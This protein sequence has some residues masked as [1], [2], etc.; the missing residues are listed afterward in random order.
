MKTLDIIKIS[1]K[2]LFRSKL[3][4]FLTVAAVFIGALTL[5]LTNG[6]GSGIKAYV[7]EQIGNVGAK[8]TLVVQM[9]QELNPTSNE[10]KKYNPNRKTGGSFNLALLGKNDIEKIKGTAGVVEVTPQYTIRLE[11]VTTGGDKYESSATQYIEGLTLAMSAGDTVQANSTDT[12]TIPDKYV[13]PLGFSSDQDAIGKALTIAFKDVSGKIV[14]RKIII[15]GVQKQSLLGSSGVNISSALAKE[16]NL[17]QTTGVSGLV[18]SYQNVIAKYDPSFSAKQISDLKERLSQVGYSSQTVEEQLGT[19]STIINTILIVL[20]VF[21]A[22]TLLAATFG[23]VNTLLMSVNER[24]SEIGLMKALGAKR[25]TVFSI[26]ALEAASIGFWGAL[27]GV[28]V[29]MGVGSIVSNIATQ[30]FLQNFVGFQ[31]VAF[32]LLPSLAVLIGIIALA[33]LAGAL[34]SLKASKLDPIKALRY[35]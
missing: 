29:S 8:D 13:R 27:L 16:I 4:T 15:E 3:R 19:I 22:I 32:P 7:N 31:L 20:N 12:V 10:L 26:F 23:I 6:V 1:Q 2:N 24:T 33:F 34:P 30:T 17:Q 21:G 28:L 9:K 18:D 35:E 11:Y 14:E 25:G 5:S